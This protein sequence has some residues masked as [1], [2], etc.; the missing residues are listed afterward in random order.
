M[1]VVLLAVEGLAT[2]QAICQR[3]FAVSLRKSALLTLVVVPGLLLAGEVW[4]E[5]AQRGGAPDMTRH[6]G[7]IQFIRENK[8]AGRPIACLPFASGNS[9]GDYDVTTRWMFYGL[10]HGAPLING[11]SGFFP[12]SYLELRN[13]VNR[14]FPSTQILARFAALGVEYVV[15]ARTYCEPETLLKLSTDDLQVQLVYQDDVGIDVYRL[16]G[17]DEAG[18]TQAMR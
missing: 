16:V 3:W 5:T 1:T 9:I 8:S 13:A 12:Q 14:E 10:E 17:A 15:V 7:W 18:S 6:A 2:M 11:Y 4:P